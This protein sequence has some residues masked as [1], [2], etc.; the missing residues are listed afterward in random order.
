MTENS[1]AGESVTVLTSDRVE[2]LL[3]RL[4]LEEKISLVHGDVDPDGMATGYVPPNDRLGI[5]SFSMI[6]GPLG[7][8]A[9]DG[10]PS[11]AFPASISLAA[12]WDPSLAHEVGEAMASE[13]RARDQDVLLA[14]GFNLIRVPQCGRSFEYYSEDPHLNSRI[15]VGTVDGIQDGGVAACAKH[16]AVNNQEHARMEDNAIVDERPLHELY[17]RAFE[18]VVKEADVA[19]LMAAYNR[20]NGTHATENRELLTDILKEDWGFEGFVVSDWWA[21][22][23]GPSAARAGLDLD[24]PGVTLPELAPDMNPAY[25]LIDTF[26][27]FSWFSTDDATKLITSLIGLRPS[28]CRV[29]RSEKF[30]ESLR[31]AIE[32]GRL[33]ESILDEKVARILG[34]MERFG[35]LDDDMPDGEANVPAHHEL[36]RRV[37][38]RGTV[39]LHNDDTLPL[40]PAT[41]DDIALIGPHADEAKTG[42]GGSS[43]VATDSTVSPLDGIR[44]RVGEDASLTFEA[45]VAPLAEMDDRDITVWNLSLSTIADS[46]FGSEEESPDVDMD[47]AVEAA[48]D[49][50][51]AVVVVQDAASEDYDRPLTLPGRQDELVSAV[52]D[53]AEETVVVLKTAGPV[54]MPWL[55]DVEAVLEAWYPGQEDGRSLASVLFGDADPSGRLPVTFGSRARDYPANTQRQYPGIDRDVT[56]EEG[57]FVGYRHFDRVETDPLFPFGHGLSYAD[58]EYSDVAVSLDESTATVEVT[59]ENV[60]DR[61]GYEVV[62]VYLGAVDPDV[63]RPPRELAAFESLELAAGE[64]QT[65][66]LSV[67]ERAFAY[68]DADQSGWVVD[69]GEYEVAVGRSSR[70]IVHSETVE[71]E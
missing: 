22:T 8:R 32:D 4:T 44:Y 6:D 33:G 69:A 34:Q 49:A 63:E 42:G 18:A 36:S 11:T 65:V 19:S 47:A 40:D 50:D 60:S 68:Y 21:T 59:V 57:I 29:Y 25:R 15:A 35:V 70:E 43:E 17:L 61:D 53:V 30:D 52:A 26:S 71:L 24:M 39:L 51:V 10:S 58:F 56:Y 27:R 1:S 48:E 2:K 41:L 55:D 62:Q 64:Q 28:E 66:S 20:V 7:V 67:D 12:A 54:E 14:P 9:G 37:A 3:S 31:E 23:D 46:Y 5:P 38:E 16:F 13:A 45:G